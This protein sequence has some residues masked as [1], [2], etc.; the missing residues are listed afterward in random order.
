MKTRYKS[1]ADYGVTDSEKIYLYDFCRNA[2]EVDKKIIKEALSELPPYI[3]PF[4][5]FS[6]TECMSYDR[7]CQKNY[8]FMDMVDFYAYRRK[9]IAAIKRWLILYGKWPY[10]T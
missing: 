9:G 3:A 5:F 7:I 2:N 6:L 4:V 1:Y 8:I 10:G